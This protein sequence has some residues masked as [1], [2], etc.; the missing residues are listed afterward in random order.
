MFGCIG[1]LVSAVVLLVAG[2]ALWHFRA[3]WLPTVKAYFEGKASEIEVD[4][5][6][7][8]ALPSGVTLEWGGQA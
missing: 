1:R 6:K 5:P 3:E 4:L 8:G 7:I 2:A